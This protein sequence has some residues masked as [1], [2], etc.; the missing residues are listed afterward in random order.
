MKLTFLGTRGYVEPRSRRHRQHAAL[1]VEYRGRDVMIDCGEDWLDSLAELRP[2]AV[3]LTHAHP[4]HAGGLAEGA[5]CPVFATEAT[6]KEIDGFPI[7][8]RRTVAPGEPFDVRGIGFQAFGLEHST[9]CPAVSYRVNAGRVAVHYAP[10]VAYIHQRAGALA[11]CDLYVGDGASLARPMIRR[12]GDHLIGHAPVRTQLTWCAKE[13][14]PRAVFTH[15]G[16]QI[17]AGDERTLGA[18]LR[19]WAQE[20]GVQAEFASDG[21]IEI[22]R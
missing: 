14:V 11:G 7:E 13:G 20:R 22:L 1:R 8:D 19:D 21:R 9:R 3:V 12:R 4:D 17:V 16:A 10:D 15:C 5:P 6:W 18:Q 2:G